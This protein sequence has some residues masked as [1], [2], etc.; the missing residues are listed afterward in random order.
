M[1][2]DDF[3]HLGELET[4]YCKL[5][6]VVLENSAMG[7]NVAMEALGHALLSTAR[8]A[9]TPLSKL[10]FDLEEMSR[11]PLPGRKASS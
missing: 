9:G 11:N 4:L 10:V 8:A 5:V 6:D 1:T 2:S 3:S 7:P